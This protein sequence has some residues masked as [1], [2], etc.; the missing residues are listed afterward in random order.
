MIGSM[1]RIGDLPTLASIPQLL[2]NE[3][4]TIAH[5]SYSS[6]NAYS[7]IYPHDLPLVLLGKLAIEYW[8]IIKGNDIR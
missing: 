1:E 4:A 6:P 7:G 8:A 2:H 5:N 3:P